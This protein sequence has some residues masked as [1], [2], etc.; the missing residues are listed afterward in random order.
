MYAFTRWMKLALEEVIR[1]VGWYEE[2]AWF[3][4]YKSW[5]K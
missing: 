3:L 5:E 4:V 2:V 1:G